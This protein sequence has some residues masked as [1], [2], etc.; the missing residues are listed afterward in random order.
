MSHY[1]RLF[2]VESCIREGRL[3]K[4]DTLD[5]DR[6]MRERTEAIP[7]PASTKNARKIT[8]SA[9]FVLFLILSHP[10]LAGEGTAPAPG[11]SPPVAVTDE[12][13]T[14][15]NIP[16]SANVLDNDSDPEGGTLTVNAETK[17]T[18]HG[19]V[20]IRA[21]G[22][23]TYTPNPN[24]HGNDTFIYTVC[25]NGSPKACCTGTVK[26]TVRCIQD[27]PIANPDFFTTNE[28]TPLATAPNS[29]LANDSDADGDAITA[30]LVIPT[31]HG[32]LV[33]NP[34]GTFTYTPVLNYNGTDTFT[35]HA[36]DGANNSAD[37]VV[38]I[39]VNPV[40]D[41]AV[42]V[43]DIISTDEDAAVNIPV[44]TND[45]DVDNVLTGSMITI[46]TQ[47]A[48]G[49]LVI[50]TSTG[51][52]KYT[53]NPNYFGSDSFT[54]K[55]NDSGSSFSNVATVSITVNPINDTPLG[56]PDSF[57]LNEDTPLVTAPNSVLTNDTDPDGDPI[58]A[59]LVTPPQHGTL[60][61]NP[62]GTFTY[63][64]VLNYNGTDT[65][66]YHANDGK[67]NST[68]QLVTITVNP[69]N[70]PA[71][72]VNDAIS[73]NEDV[74]V[75]IPVLSNDTDVD[76]VLTGSMIRIVTQ[77]AHG[78]LVINT[79]T[80]IVTYT[81]NP[82]YYGSDSFTYKLNDSG[83][84]FSNVA[85]VSIT[86]NP[87]S[88]APSANPDSFTV[89][90][91]TKLVTSPNSVL[92][93]DTDPEGGPI[94][95]VLVTP[96]QHGTLVLNPNGTFTYTPVP[97]YNGTDTFT[98]HAN[99]GTNNSTDQLVTIT[100]IPVNDPAIAANDA[101][102]TDEDMAVN[103][104]VL[105]NDTDVDNVLT[106]SMIKI[107][108]QPAHGTL[109]I[110][111]STGIVT[112]TPNPNYY[113]ND[114]F[115][116][117]LNDSGS[118]FSNVAT[119]SI[120]VNPVNDPPI[121]NPDQAT[122][123]EDVAVVIS[124][125]NNDTDSDN[126]IV[127]SSVAVAGNPSHGSVVAQPSTGT[128][129]Y[130]PDKD[131]YGTDSFTYTVADAGGKTSSPGNVTIVVT[132]VNDAPVAVDDA[133]TTDEN[134]AVQIPVLANDFDVDDV[135]DPSSLII[136]SNPQHGTISVNPTTGVVTYT[137]VTDYA[138]NDSFSYTVED[139]AG[140]VS[141]PATVSITVID[142]N[143][144]PVAVD[145]LLQH[146]SVAP[147]T[148][149]VMANDYDPD[150]AH[151]E[152]SIVSVTNP[153]IGTVS[154]VDGTIVYTPSG[155]FSTTVTFSYTIT[156]P[157]GLT[158]DAVV[159]IEYIYLELIVSQGF[160]PNGDGNND[161]WYIKGIEGYPNNT[162]KVYDRWG[163]LVYQKSG[164]E[165]TIAPWDGRG[166]TGQMA[167]KLVDRGTYFY[168]LEPGNGLKAL[169]GYVMVVR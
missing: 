157:G 107:V 48:H 118:S 112:Y 62:N 81:P 7:K 35:Y 60:V 161:T 65:F 24:Y 72:A 151:D 27:P 11:N 104:P 110:N 76:N 44:L 128:F 156:D 166:N 117:K 95:A 119:V 148:I 9:V 13:T 146:S 45:T 106:G 97:N 142:I 1:N 169:N 25:D 101:I 41:P 103:I 109:V 88:D 147:I 54:Y 55:L 152:L 111:T 10:L 47:P 32:T 74:A 46:V 5:D 100:V 126:T 2:C 28:D 43:N 158:D 155:T 153:S 64:P 132:P 108:T 57:T 30:V 83:S 34:N 91:D 50:N 26:I 160:S 131:Y 120:T 49:T 94:T 134:T 163:L 39:T 129:L 96:P 20:V 130:T 67:V 123:P 168:I 31:Q 61:L 12:V 3:Q 63:T 51:I 154:I 167:G 71:I 85:T 115:T 127:A 22:T 141:A 73:T 82:N 114:S 59:V 136:T 99:D 33:L 90:E 40:N 133:A 15:E 23:F 36:T 75:N 58:T 116:Y 53:P 87:V 137:P 150:N 37:Q 80:G 92:T 93:N 124:V 77:P 145:D 21:D 56:N 69:V 135:V 138:G 86:V 42:A 89:N 113:G 84:S 29:V 14:D 17:N 8:F 143:L 98:Y 144:P 6:F 162:V 159:T 102:S 121:A 68:D 78:T 140:L 52:V 164:Y 4:T 149:D 165:N 122:T 125:L 16:V 18:A 66:T 79:S 19:T 139:P 105:A 70:D 38:T